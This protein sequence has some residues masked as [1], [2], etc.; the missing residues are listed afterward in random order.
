M[1]GEGEEDWTRNL[2]EEG[3]WVRS[4]MWHGWKR[5]KKGKSLTRTTVSRAH[6][7]VPAPHIEIKE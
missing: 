6:V 4:D 1:S 2:K 7:I 3:L 5:A